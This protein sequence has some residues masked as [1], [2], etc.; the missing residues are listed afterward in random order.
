MRYSESPATRPLDQLVD[1][2]WTLTS[3]GRPPPRDA[4]V[5][6]PDGAVEIVIVC[7][8][9]VTMPPARTRLRRFV[10]GPSDRVR[11]LRYQGAIDLAGVRLRPTAAARLFKN[12]VPTMADRIVPLVD[13]LPDLDR[14]IASATASPQAPNQVLT[15]LGEA[16]E[17]HVDAG[18]SPNPILERATSE[19]RRQHGRV[20]IGRLARNLGISQRQLERRFLAG[21]GLSPKRWCR[22]TRFQAALQALSSGRA[23]VDLAHDFGYA[24]QAHFSRE[25]RAFAGEPPSTAAWMRS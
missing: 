22:I 18:R 21:L 8:G 17:R 12:S 16:L 25:F 4:G 19:I 14:A 11:R 6:L 20:R 5:I 7:R 9:V 24:D 15:W 23:W 2:F 10:L 1:A 3:D 13:L